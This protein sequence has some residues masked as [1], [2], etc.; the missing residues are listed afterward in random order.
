MLGA[1]HLPL[2]KAELERESFVTGISGLIRKNSDIA[3]QI[4]NWF[5]WF[6]FEETAYKYYCEEYE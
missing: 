6:A 3:D 4:K 5:A 1:N 2:N